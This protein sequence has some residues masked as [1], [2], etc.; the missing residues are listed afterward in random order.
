MTRQTV[1][2]FLAAAYAFLWLF[3]GFA[4]IDLTA[5]WDPESPVV[6]EAGWGLLFGALVTAPLVAL[7]FRPDSPSLSFN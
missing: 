6:L 5:T 3:P 7:A 2:R 1:L 4:I